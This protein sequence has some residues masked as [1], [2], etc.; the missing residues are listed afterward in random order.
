MGEPKLSQNTR[1]YLKEQINP[2]VEFFPIEGDEK[3]DRSFLDLSRPDCK[4]LRG[5]L[6]RSIGIY[7]F[8]N[9]EYELIYLGKTKSSLWAEMKHAYN[10]TMTDY[11]RFKVYHPS[12]VYKPTSGKVRVIQR[13]SIHLY[14]C[15]AYFSAYSIRDEVLIDVLELMMIRMCPND[16]LNVRME[17]NMTLS[18]L[19]TV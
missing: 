12:D 15:A 19:V 14:D 2:I 4:K 7:S 9:S 16:I 6:D 11:S 3:S 13:K 18:P 17:G 8:Y 10:R 5:D 1:K